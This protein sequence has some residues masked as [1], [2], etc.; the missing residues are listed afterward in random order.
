MLVVCW[1]QLV[2]LTVVTWRCVL[3][4]LVRYYGCLVMTFSVGWGNGVQ[5]VLVILLCWVFVVGYNTCG[6]TVLVPLT[7]RKFSSSFDN[8]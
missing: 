1:C 5:R 8:A 4:I 3:R 7:F 2:D 6:R